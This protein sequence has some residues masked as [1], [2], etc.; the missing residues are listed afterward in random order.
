MLRRNGFFSKALIILVIIGELLMT[1]KGAG[2][3]AVMMKS[4]VSMKKFVCISTNCDKP[5]GTPRIM[6]GTKNKHDPRFMGYK[7]IKR[8][9]L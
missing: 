7:P 1:K 3:K 8:R 5:R 2:F 6:P 4:G 9:W